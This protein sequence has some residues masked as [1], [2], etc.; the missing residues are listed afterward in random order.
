MFVQHK[1][2][3]SLNVSA[4]KIHHLHEGSS[5]VQLAFS[6]YPPQLCNAYLIW[7]AGVEKS[8]VVVGFYLNESDRS[9]FFVPKAGEVPSAQAQRLYDEGFFFIE[10]MGFVMV[11]TDFHLLDAAAKENY[12]RQLPVS[13]GS[14]KVQGGGT[15]VASAKPNSAQSQEI[16]LQ[17]VALQSLGRF[18]SAM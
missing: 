8:L 16:T 3:K 10:A 11:E 9:I 17:S 12:W 4:G 6:G 7:V 2:L 14:R 18:W 5:K 15:A 1:N 13:Q